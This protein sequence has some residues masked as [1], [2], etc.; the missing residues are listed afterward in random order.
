MSKDKGEPQQDG[1]RGKILFRIKPHMQQN[2]QRAQAKLCVH[3]E[4]PQGLSQTCL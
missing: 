4:N 3:Q 1:R 2:A